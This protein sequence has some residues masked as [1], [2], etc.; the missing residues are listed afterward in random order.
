LNFGPHLATELS[1]EV[2]QWFVH[3]K[4]R[5]FTNDRTAKRDTLLLPTGEFRWTLVEQLLDLEQ[6]GS[7]F[8][9][10]F[11]FRFSDIGR[12]P[13]PEANIGLDVHVGVQRIVLEHHRRIPLLGGFVSDFFPVDVD[14][15]ARRPFEARDRIQC[16]TLP[17]AAR[18]NDDHEL[19]ILDV[20]IQVFDGYNTSTVELLDQILDL[21]RCHTMNKESVFLHNNFSLGTE[22]RSVSG[23]E[24]RESDPCVGSESHEP[25][26]RVDQRVWVYLP[27]I[28][29]EGAV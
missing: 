28:I 18:T 24:N 3:Q 19:P 26:F 16:R 5:R 15:T 11:P 20:E 10:L 4:H 8:D 27:P 7:I 2:T 22:R 9:A 23:E 25:R 13:E 21:K 14:R 17:T 12:H 1:V 6:L 29:R